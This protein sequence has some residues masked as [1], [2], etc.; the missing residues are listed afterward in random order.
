M[1]TQ[2][3]PKLP[4]AVSLCD[5]GTNSHSQCRLPTWFLHAASVDVRISPPRSSTPQRYDRRI[6]PP[7]EPSH[8]I[9]LFKSP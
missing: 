6:D 5:V 1:S 7:I 8:N 9:S 3:S 4:A 2:R